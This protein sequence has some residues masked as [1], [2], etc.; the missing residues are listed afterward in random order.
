PMKPIL[1]VARKEMAIYFNSPIAYIVVV[2]F[3]AF[4]SSWFFYIQQ[5]L[6]QNVASMRSFFGIVPVVF[7]ILLPAV[8]MRS[9]AEEHKLGTD[10]VLLTLPLSEAQAVVGKFCGAMGL[11]VI[12]LALT[13]PVPLTIS[14]LG[15]FA[16]GQ[17]IGQYIGTLLLGAAAISVGLFVSSLS[18]NQITAF[19]LGVVVLLVLTL[20]NQVNVVVD[21]PRRLGGLLNQISLNHHFRS[22]EKGLLDSRDIIYYVLLAFLFL[23]LNT[24][25][26]IFRKWR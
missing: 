19:I 13:L 26:L 11:L 2:F 21:L 4:T 1:T 14:P 3:L 10:E 22:F 23:Y 17:I 8:T 5:F 9:W 24:K 15:D 20:V 7:V 6:A 25:V 12:M 16:T 18:Q